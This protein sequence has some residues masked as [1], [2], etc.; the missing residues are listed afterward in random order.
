MSDKEQV[1]DLMN[2]VQAVYLATMDGRLPRIRALTNLRHS[3]LCPTSAAFC[4]A[5]GFTCYL[6][7]SAAS[8]KVAQLRVHPEASLYYSDPDSVH[9]I[10][11]SGRMEILADAQLKHRLW[12]D[13]WRIYW[14]GPDDP[15]YIVL[16]LKPVEAFGWWGTQPFKLDLGQP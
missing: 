3:G 14:S 15:D 12:S 9:G 8:S 5:E 10:M 1:L 2:A 7:T 6:A 13:G 11:L 4:Q 16:R